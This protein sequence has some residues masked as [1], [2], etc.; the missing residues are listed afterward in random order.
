MICKIETVTALDAEKISVGPALVAVVAADDFHASVR[1]AH[2]QRRLAAVAAVRADRAHVLHLPRTG[3]VAISTRGER[4]DRTDVDTH[5][6]LFAFQVIFFIGR[7]QRT[8]AAILHTESPYIHA[9]AA[10]AHA[11]ET[12]DA[13]RAVEENYRRP[14]LLLF[15]GL[16]LHVSRL[17]GAVGK[18]HVLQFALAARVANRAIQR[19]IAEQDLNRRFTRLPDFFAVGGDDH[20]FADHRGAG[21]LELWR[22][23]DLYHAHAAS[24]AQREV[25]VITERRYLDAHR[26]AGLNQKRARGSGDFLAVD[27]ER[28]EF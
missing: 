4:T 7:D 13:A 5:A 15:V 3:L 28:N 6:A 23:L 11:T 21:S 12:Q 24:A 16:R 22:F 14:L 9:L 10:N 20:A 27:R 18:S 25:R 26:L 1:P 19:M 2:A 17:R 8:D